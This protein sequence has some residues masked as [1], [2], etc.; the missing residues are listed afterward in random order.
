[1]E[2]NKGKRTSPGTCRIFSKSVKELG[3]PSKTCPKS[4]E[5]DSPKGSIEVKTT[6]AGEKITGHQ[7]TED[8]HDTAKCTG[9][10]LSISH[11]C[12]ERRSWKPH[13]KHR[14]TSPYS[15]PRR[16]QS[17][18]VLSGTLL[19][20]HVYSLG[21]RFGVRRRRGRKY[22]RS[23]ENNNESSSCGKDKNV[24]SRQK[25]NSSDYNIN[26][27]VMKE[28]SC[29]NL[30]CIEKPVSSISALGSSQLASKFHFTEDWSF[31][32]RS[33]QQ[34]NDAED[35]ANLD[36]KDSWVK[37]NIASGIAENRL[38]KQCDAILDIKDR[39]TKDSPVENRKGN[40]R[41][42]NIES[43]LCNRTMLL[44][45]MQSTPKSCGRQK[46]LQT[47]KRIEVAKDTENHPSIPNKDF[48]KEIKETAKKKNSVNNEC[49]EEFLK[50]EIEMSPQHEKCYVNSKSNKE[51]DYVD[52]TNMGNILPNSGCLEILTKEENISVGKSESSVTFTNNIKSLQKEVWFDETQIDDKI[53]PLVE[54]NVVEVKETDVEKGTEC[55]VDES[56][57]QNKKFEKCAQETQFLSG[58]HLVSESKAKVNKYSLNELLLISQNI[59][60]KESKMKSYIDKLDLPLEAVLV[61]EEP[62]VMLNLLT[63]DWQPSDALFEISHGPYYE[64]SQSPYKDFER[65]FELND[66]GLSNV[67]EEVHDSDRDQP[68]CMFITAVDQT[69]CDSERGSKVFGPHIYYGRS[70]SRC[71][72]GTSK[73]YAIGNRERFGPN[74]NSQRFQAIPWTEVESGYAEFNCN[75]SALQSHFRTRPID[76]LN[77]GGED[78][79]PWNGPQSEDWT[80]EIKEITVDAT[81]ANSEHASI[82]TNEATIIT[83]QAE[84][85]NYCVKG[86]TDLKIKLQPYLP[87]KPDVNEQLA[88]KASASNGNIC[89]DIE[90]HLEIITVYEG[91]SSSIHAGNTLPV[92]SVDVSTDANPDP[93]FPYLPPPPPMDENDSF[94][95][96]SGAKDV[97]TNEV[98]QAKNNDSRSN[99]LSKKSATK[100]CAWF[101][102]LGTDETSSVSSYQTQPE[103]VYLN[104]ASETEV[105]D[106]PLDEVV[107]VENSK[108][109]DKK[110]ELTNENKKKSRNLYEISGKDYENS[111]DYYD[112]YYGPWYSE[113]PYGHPSYQNWMDYNYRMQQA[114]EMYHWQQGWYQDLVPRERSYHGSNQQSANFSLHDMAHQQ[115]AKSSGSDGAHQQWAKSSGSDGAQQQWAK[116]SE[117]DGS[118]Q[119]WAKSSESDGD[120]AHQ[121]WAKSS[122]SDGAHQQWA[123][124][125]ESDGVHHQWAKSSG[126]DGAHQQWTKSSG[127]V[128]AH[129]QW[130]KS[131]ES[132]RA[133]QQWA[134]SSES[135]G[136]H[137]QWAK[138]SE[139]HGA[140]QQWAKS[141][142]SDGA[143]Q[144]WAKSSGSDG[145]HHQQWAKSSGSD[146]ALAKMRD[147]AH[148]QWEK[149]SGSDTAH[150][151]MA[152]NSSPEQL[153]ANGADKQHKLWAESPVMDNAY[154]NCSNKI[155]DTID[156]RVPPNLTVQIGSKDY[157]SIQRDV[158][159]QHL[160]R[161]SDFNDKNHPTD[162]VHFT[163]K[164]LKTCGKNATHETR[165]TLPSTILHSKVPSCEIETSEPIPCDA[166]SH[167]RRQMRDQEK[168]RWATSDVMCR[169]RPED[170][171]FS[172]W[173]SCSCPVGNPPCMVR[174][175]PSLHHIM[176]EDSVD[177]GYQSYK[178]LGNKL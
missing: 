67:E 17:Q 37:G 28:S 20:K 112:N 165:R 128:G 92:D 6:D 48:I 89:N 97:V 90:S 138:W 1:M 64:R 151:P 5:K 166:E 120:G 153:W 116:S 140:H 77:I 57:L 30:N 19:T 170:I 11:S 36:M 141:F 44:P 121:Q 96:E 101:D 164:S 3:L 7:K 8:T 176:Q 4:S 133:H 130:T 85:H 129:Q 16:S 114:W 56:S 53:Q 40:Q 104:I 15:S 80:L 10:D 111:Y 143:Y 29:S 131:S 88:V 34:G 123:K 137:Q 134:K 93:M 132:D 113:S 13:D 158:N 118:H 136:A 150:L 155:K 157:N 167:I 117:S 18:R 124:S 173:R 105:S 94:V 27:C 126:S 52:N 61:D 82:E 75:N 174:T 71:L 98:R 78:N 58:E 63:D 70:A 39:C 95:A 87:P 42:I 60:V 177:M 103:A 145:A 109:I 21:P 160:R 50:T 152:K 147:S 146:M 135:D 163:N 22:A 175:A 72:R 38:E 83:E 55:D 68:T 69:S 74:Y 2:H 106:L 66:Q 99:D 91:N 172:V 125:S 59:R 144:Q 32:I 35:P 49:N 122:G 178:S 41:I 161:E 79:K 169:C 162:A 110:K 159:R 156:C 62:D 47:N 127:S 54:Q 24:L 171:H 76:N 102:D 154:D 9:S 84:D 108:S 43:G 115:W 148:Q 33:E 45:Q 149:S 51:D 25:S 65:M 73:N 12:K 139:S 23:Q 46:S 107:E 14:V 26:S 81:S 142:E 31:E 168:A 86:N 119:Q 100:I